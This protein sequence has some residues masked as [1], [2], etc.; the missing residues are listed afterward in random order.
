MATDKEIVSALHHRISSLEKTKA[1]SELV[2][3][4]FQHIRDGLDE[5][6]AKIDKEHSCVNMP[7]L[8]NLQT[9]V[10]DNASNIKKLYAWQA[11]VGISLLVFFLTAGVAALRFVDS[12]DHSV[13]T[14]EVRLIAIEDD[15]EEQRNTNK[16]LTEA[17]LASIKSHSDKK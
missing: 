13:K 15:S 12:I 5:V 8:E 14:N 17:L 7:L 2:T 16:E 10:R 11:S 3:V 4:E 6:K 9:Q 1:G